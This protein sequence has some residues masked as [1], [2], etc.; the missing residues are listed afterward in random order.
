MRVFLRQIRLTVFT[1][2]KYEVENE[3]LSG[4]SGV[5][6]RECLLSEKKYTGWCGQLVRCR[7]LENMINKMPIKGNG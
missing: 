4:E 5:N 1:T 7:R 2:S 3:V 6:I